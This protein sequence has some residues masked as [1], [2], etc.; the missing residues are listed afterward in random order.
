MSF[1]FFETELKDLILIAPK[2]FK[3]S[4]GWFL[5]TYKEKEFKKAGIEELF[6]QDNLSLSF[7][8]VLRGIHFQTE[9]MAQG[10]LIYVPHGKVW[11]VVV[12]LR[13]QSKTYK[14]W[15]GTELSSE[16][17]FMLYVPPGFGH[18]FLTLEDNTYFTYKCTNV[19]SPEHESGIRWDDPC[20]SIDWPLTEI[21]VSEKDANLPFLNELE[22]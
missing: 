17:H 19:Y 4:R 8:G 13:K 9:P 16:N 20:L 12:D 22:L 11:D 7:K 3:D 10:K 1:E 15:I 6:V 21:T 5:E 2:I 14:K 18:G